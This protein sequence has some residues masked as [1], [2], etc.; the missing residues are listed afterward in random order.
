MIIVFLLTIGIRIMFLKSNTLN[1]FI[2][3]FRLQKNIIQ[4]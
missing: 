2:S 1:L 4:F 3:I